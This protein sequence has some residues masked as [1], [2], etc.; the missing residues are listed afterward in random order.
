MEVQKSRKMRPHR[1]SS[2]LVDGIRSLEYDSAILE[3][4]SKVPIL[5]HFIGWCLCVVGVHS[6]GLIH[7]YIDT[8][9]G[10]VHWN[11]KAYLE[12]DPGLS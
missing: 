10:L 6:L 1:V 12:A 8:T 2:P 9:L 5:Y 3:T 7:D 4:I 11:S